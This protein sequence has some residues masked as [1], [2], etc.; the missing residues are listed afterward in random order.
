MVILQQVFILLRNYLLIQLTN[1]VILV[2]AIKH[3]ILSVFKLQS[4]FIHTLML[5]FTLILHEAYCLQLITYSYCIQHIF[6]R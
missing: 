4:A 2:L 1:Q 6:V 5:L 3:T